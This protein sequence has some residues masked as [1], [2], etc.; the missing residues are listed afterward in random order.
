V[1]VAD[2]KRMRAKSILFRYSPLCMA[3]AIVAFHYRFCLKSLVYGLSLWDSGWLASVTYRSGWQLPNPQV[4]AP[5]PSFNGVHLSLAT[6]GASL[7]SKWYPGNRF[8][9]FALFTAIPFGLIALAVRSALPIPRSS[10]DL[11]ALL[12]AQIV[13]CTLGHALAFADFPHFEAYAAA[14]IG[15]FA[16]GL[17]KQK[18]PL[19][20]AGA[21]IALCA[22]ED[23]GLHLLLFITTTW[24]LSPRSASPR[25]V[26]LGGMIGAAAIVLY[27]AKSQFKSY[28]L[29]RL[30]YLGDPPFAHVSIKWVL[31]RI[32]SLVSDGLHMVLG[33]AALCAYAQFGRGMR[34]RS[35]LLVGL[36]AVTPWAL[37]NQF[38]AD[39]NKAGVGVY[40]GFPFVAAS[41]WAATTLQ[42]DTARVAKHLV[43]LTLL[44]SLGW[45]LGRIGAHA[46]AIRRMQV[47]ESAH[48]AAELAGLEERLGPQLA[49]C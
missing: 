1:L 6:I 21:L 33:A 37:L 24:T 12:S 35:K 44:V 49:A 3:I 7:L 31:T 16:V 48:A 20:C 2:I 19:T 47:S 39:D 8:E 18:A 17:A 40:V 29:A 9:W 14:G 15:L 28:E 5:V 22:R 25:A 46:T 45:E 23:V 13:F 41:L 43:A 42:G 10:R 26:R 32:Y 30:V 11:A 27:I 4:V 34:G 38:A 36:I